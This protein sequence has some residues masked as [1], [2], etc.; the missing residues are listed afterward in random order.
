MA[1]PQSWLYTEILAPDFR[2]LILIGLALC[3]MFSLLHQ[4]DWGQYNK[5]IW[6]LFLVTVLAF[7][8]WLA[9]GG[10]GRYFTPFL[11]VVGPLCVALLY[12]FRVTVAMKLALLTLIV[13][14]QVFV[15]SVN[16]PWTSF[17]SLEWVRWR[18][19]ES[20]QLDVSQ[21]AGDADV[22]Y[23][24]ITD[25]TF[26]IINHHFPEGSHWINLS[27]FK[28]SDFFE[29]HRVLDQ[30]RA[31]LHSATK[32][33]LVIHAQ[34]RQANPQNG[35]PNELAIKGM[36]SYL[37]PFGLMIDNPDQCQLLAST[38]LSELTLLASDD[39]PEVRGRL[40]AQSGVWLC[41]LQYSGVAS[42]LPTKQV[43]GDIGEQVI[44]KVE[45]LCPRLFPAG[46]K[47]FS[48]LPYGLERAYT[49]SDSKLTYVK[50]SGEL[51]VK[52]MRAL[53][54]ERIGK[55]EEIVSS[56]FA[57]DCNNFVSRN[58]FPWDRGI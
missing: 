55:A 29:K 25:Q 8:P 58:G 35:V 32:L 1:I 15:V 43:S 45:S 51:Y 5:R 26:S 20:F 53:N 10:N 47:I 39:S 42:S 19:N 9:T 21:V 22:T 16:S 23:V 38:T 3:F 46:Q 24:S 2:F 57:L 7:G 18:S 41:P 36:N 49:A 31:K 28:G 11:L 14:A 37:Q 33:R 27:A 30:A 17:D 40:K 6:A 52:F 4:K 48:R 56:D 44:R 34:P 54:P 12:S 13:S 50:S